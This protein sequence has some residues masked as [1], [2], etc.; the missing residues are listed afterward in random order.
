MEKAVLVGVELKNASEFFYIEDSL[1]EL[2][3]LANS[4]GIEVIS[5]VRQKRETPNPAYFIGRGKLEEIHQLVK[6]IS[7]TTLVFDDTLS[8]TQ[9]RNLET[10]LGVKVL[11]RTRVILDIFNQRAHTKEA[12]LQVELARLDYLLPRLTGRGL[13]LARQ[14]GMVGARAGPGEKKLEVDRRR[15]RD[16]ITYLKK[17]IKK[18]VS[19]REVQRRQREKALLPVVALVGYTNA[20]KTTLLNRLSSTQELVENKLFTT[21]DSVLRRVVLPDSRQILL[22]D[23]VG[24]IY[25]LPH[26]LVAAFRATL[27][28]ARNADLLVHVVDYHLPQFSRQIE[29]VKGVLEEIGAGDKPVLT[30]YNKID[31]LDKDF[32]R[33]A[34]D[35]NSYISAL[36]GDGCDKL[37]ARIGEKLDSL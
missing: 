34:F 13:D 19:S 30:V 11:D 16:R 2:E 6:K 3:S 17:A 26:Q 35:E 7:A 31:Y 36:A 23:T 22:S 25:K 20:G 8:P 10:Y 27:E 12:K 9:Q 18:V 5:T 33:P 1:K 37:L 29:V 24:F 32:S 21:L 14:F 15:V 28:E 4:I